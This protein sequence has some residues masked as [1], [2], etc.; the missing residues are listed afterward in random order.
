MGTCCSMC[1]AVALLGVDAG[2][3]PLADG[4]L[5]YIIRLTPLNVES[6]RAGQDVR[7]DIPPN[8]R[9]VRSYRITTGTAELPRQQASDPNSPPALN[10]APADSAV[11]SGGALTSTFKPSGPDLISATGNPLSPAPGPI[12]PAAPTPVTSSGANPTSAETERASP[13][14]GNSPEIERAS[15]SAVDQEPLKASRPLNVILLAVAAGS[16]AGMLYFGWVAHDYRGRYLALL[17]ESASRGP[18]IP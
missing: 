1:L 5:E 4:G 14:D 10:R 15:Q 12:P 7:S 13:N 6:L 3:Q 17:E 18:V 9:G 2:W 16:F 8:V 11:P